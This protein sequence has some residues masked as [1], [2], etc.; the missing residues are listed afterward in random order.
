MD[1]N[2]KIKNIKKALDWWKEVKLTR[3]MS[4]V[5]V[6]R[7][8]NNKNNNEVLKSAQISGRYYR[9]NT[10]KNNKEHIKYKRMDLWNLLKKKLKHPKEIK[11]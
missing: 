10:N 7:D 1:E 11:K 9:E 5:S 3:K 6:G 4:R 8:N 2:L